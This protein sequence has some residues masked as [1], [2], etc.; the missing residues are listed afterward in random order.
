MS[1]QAVEAA[2][3]A[4][5]EIEEENE[6]LRAELAAAQ[7]RLRDVAAQDTQDISSALQQVCQWP[8]YHRTADA[9]IA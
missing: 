8:L 5:K 3:E 4:N 2:N 1:F 6:R 7:E 9:T